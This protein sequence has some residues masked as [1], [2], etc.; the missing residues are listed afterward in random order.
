LQVAGA[1]IQ[2][3]AGQ[4]TAYFNGVTGIASMAN[5]DVVAANLR[6]V[7]VIAKPIAGDQAA[8]A[9]AT[10]QILNTGSSYIQHFDSATATVIPTGSSAAAN[11]ALGYWHTYGI[12]S[13][14]DG[15]SGRFFVD[16]GGSIW[17][18]ASA[19]AALRVASNGSSTF[20]RLRVLEVIASSDVVTSTQAAALFA[21]AKSFYGGMTWLS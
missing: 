8:S 2:E 7:I 6:S 18:N 20:R 4:R 13:S 9:G 15:T 5:G 11:A 3:D 19:P 12:A 16:N 21:N 14:A 10:F 1:S 17:G